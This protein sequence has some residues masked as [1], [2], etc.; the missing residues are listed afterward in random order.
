MLRILVVLA[1]LS[2]LFAQNLVPR[3]VRISGESFVQ[4]GTNESIVLAGPNIVVKGPPYLPSVSGDTYC[5]DVVNDDCTATGTCKSC[6]TFNE[7]DVAHIKSKGWNAIRL[8]VTWAGAQPVEGD[9]LDPAFVRSLHDILTLTDKSGL[10]V[11]LDNHG[12][13]TGSLG[14]GNGVPAW[15]QKKAAP[16]LVGKPLTT[17][18]PFSLVPSMRIEN[19]DGYS[20]CGSDEAKWSANAGDPNYNLLNECCQAMNSP[21]PAAIGYSRISQKTIDYMLMEGE[22]R[23]A[24]VRYWQ[25]L[26]Q[27]VV[28]HPSAVAMELDNEPMSIRRGAMYDTW[29]AAAEAINAIIPDMSVSVSDTGEGTLMPAVVTKYLGLANLDIKADT[30]EWMKSSETLFYAWHW[31]GAPSDPAAAV[32]NAQAKGKEWNMPT[33]AT[34]FMD[35]GAWTAAESAGISHSYWHYSSYCNTGPSFANNA[36]HDTFGAC[37][38]GWAGGNSD[39]SC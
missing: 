30:V 26:A 32:K 28:A 10:H 18:L 23:D 36:D 2:L 12:D 35:C 9:S 6:Y 19:L 3:N 22:G 29:R 39:Y 16:E 17:G 15:F 7:F 4:A 8:A 11:I 1:S 21:N 20:V 27:E 37:I 13:M 14:C 5:D 33:F 34:E 38:L 24:F 31:Y 25:L